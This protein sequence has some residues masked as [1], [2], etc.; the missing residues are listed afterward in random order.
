MAFLANAFSLQMLKG[1]PA[2]VNIEEIAAGEVPADVES[3][4]G[5]ADTAAVVSDILGIKG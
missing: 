3:A 1:L 2:Q 4:I 5:H